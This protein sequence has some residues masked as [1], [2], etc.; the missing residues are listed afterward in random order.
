MKSRVT[1][2]VTVIIVSTLAAVAYY[3]SGLLNL[4]SVPD[5]VTAQA[6]G[7]AGLSEMKSMDASL[8]S[9][10]SSLNTNAAATRSAL[11]EIEK[12]NEQVGILQLQ[13]TIQHEPTNLVLGNVLRM[14]MMLTRER[15]C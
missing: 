9:G 13:E 8:T 4:P 5:D 3:R 2:I 11:D 7:L 6:A 14:E 15:K 1:I 10:S 12:G